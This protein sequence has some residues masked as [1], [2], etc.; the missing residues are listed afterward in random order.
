MLEKAHA[1][2]VER[3]KLEKTLLDKSAA[4]NVMT[5]SI[6][7]LERTINHLKTEKRLLK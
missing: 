4:V 6:A 7:D 2:G 1:Y 3:K 5:L